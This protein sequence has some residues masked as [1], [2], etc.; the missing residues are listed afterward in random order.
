ME[1]FLAAFI[2]FF[3]VIDPIGVAPIFASL[4][5]GTPAHYRRKMAIRSIGVAAAVLLGFAFGGEALLRALHIE[6]YS[7]SIAGGLMLL[8]IALEMVFEKRTKRREN[9]VTDMAFEEGATPAETAEADL[10]DISVF[11][12]AIPMVA[13]PGAIASIMLLMSRHQGDFS[14]QSYVLGAMA[15]NL[16]ACLV[17]FLGA[18]V[19]MR[20]IGETIAAMITRV[21]GVILVALAA[22]LIL[23]GI[24]SSFGLA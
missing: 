13:G 6:L 20:L 1:V 10:E 17:L 3:V 24:K 22:Q 14:A 19:L 2:T 12:M 15:A 23:D 8:I 5:E 7:F 16:L 9:R 21:L 11:P 18:G 4:T